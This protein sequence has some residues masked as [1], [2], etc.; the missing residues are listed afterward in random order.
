[1]GAHA[2]HILAVEKNAAL[3]DPAEAHKAARQSRLADPVAAE[4]GDDLPRVHRQ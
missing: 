2:A 3:G 4:Q 1:V